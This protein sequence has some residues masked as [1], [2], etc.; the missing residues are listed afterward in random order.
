MCLNIVGLSIDLNQYFNANNFINKVT[1]TAG[2][3]V[4]SSKVKAAS[5]VVALHDG[6]FKTAAL[7]FLEVDFELGN[8]FNSTVSDE[9]IGLYGTICALATFSRQEL[10]RHFVEKK[11]FLNN[12]TSLSPEVKT[13]ALGFIH[14]KYESCLKQLEALKPRLLLDVHLSRYASSL[15]TMIAEKILVQYFAPY[16]AVSLTRMA[17][18][19]G[20][21]YAQLEA[22]L[23]SLIASGRI[24]ARIDSQG[25]TLHRTSEDSRRRMVDRVVALT[26]A[27]TSAVKRDML[28]LSLL[29]QGL[30]VESAAEGGGGRRSQQREVEEGGHAAVP[31]SAGGEWL[32]GVFNFFGGGGAQ[33]T[34][35]QGEFLMEDDAAIAHQ[36]E[37][38][39]GGE[40][41]DFGEY[42]DHESDDEEGRDL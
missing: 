34:A 29:Q 25:Q 42:D 12:Y 3:V 33:P 13:L 39:Y 22:S 27:H 15:T 26:K 18:A 2:D 16:K 8:Q 14:G 36:M 4:L 35:D 10:R 40:D 38:C 32:G 19:L 11:A 23:A 5:G 21:S 17:A 20:M 37:G 28:R 9:D 41:G 7:K 6:L 1:D 31:G 24:P 30:A